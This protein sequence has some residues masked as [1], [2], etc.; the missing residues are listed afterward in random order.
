MKH[1]LK[2][3]FIILFLSFIFLANSNAASKWGRGELQL[4][5]WVV[6]AFIK[7]VKG[8]YS[9]SPYM[10]AVSE[11]GQNYQYYICQY[12][13][14]CS[15]GDEQILQECQNYAGGVECSLFSLRRTIRWKNDINPG[16]GKAS[17]INSKWSEKQIRDKLTELGFLGNINSSN[18]TNTSNST[19]KEIASKIRE[20]KKLL[21]EGIITQDEFD[22]AK[23]KILN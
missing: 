5:D 7:Y 15:G 19:D 10:F 9:N 18:N 11:D 22:Q 14:N 4:S 21:D 16:K 12:G 8:N 1:L 13:T 2:N 3:F 20:I 23:K 6:N 17:K